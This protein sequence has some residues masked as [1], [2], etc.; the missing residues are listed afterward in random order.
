MTLMKLNDETPHPKMTLSHVVAKVDAVAEMEQ[1]FARTDEAHIQSMTDIAKNLT[2]PKAM[3]VLQRSE[4]SKKITSLIVGGSSLRSANIHVAKGFGG[5]DGARKLLNDMI[6][7]SMSKYDAE[8]AK[9]TDYYAKQCAL[10][11]V[12]RGQIS[13]S[14]FIAA[15][16]RALILD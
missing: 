15:T 1:V 9:C 7:E 6:H 4:F 13:A 14:N 2:L 11:E 10:M 3:D 8:I 5:I 16:S 12:A